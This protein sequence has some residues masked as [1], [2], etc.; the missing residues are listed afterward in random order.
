[1][2]PWFGFQVPA[3]TP[4]AV[5]QTLNSAFNTSVQNPRILKRLEDAGLRVVGGAPEK[6]GD[7]ITSEFARWAKVVKD[8]NI[9]A[10]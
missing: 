6:L 8:N 2:E 7:Q 4:A 10:D 1:V 5:I 9:K 3:G